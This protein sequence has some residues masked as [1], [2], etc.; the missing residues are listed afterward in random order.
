M[1][2][3]AV[4]KMLG[5]VMAYAVSSLGL[6]LAYYNYRKRVIKAEKIFTGTAKAIIWA[7]AG[8]ALVGIIFISAATGPEGVS[9]WKEFHMHVIGVVG[10]VAIFAF[11][12]WVTWQLYKHFSRKAEEEKK[13]GE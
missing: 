4:G 8:L 3:P 13:H 11:S 9:M 10:P 6:L 2:N 1:E 7:I 5:M 12:F